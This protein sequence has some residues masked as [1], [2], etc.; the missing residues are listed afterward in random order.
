[1]TTHA[2]PLTE[3]HFEMLDELMAE[4]PHQRN[5]AEHIVE[6]IF[7]TDWLREQFKGRSQHDV[8]DYVRDNAARFVRKRSDDPMSVDLF[9]Y[10]TDSEPDWLIEGL[11]ERHTRTIFTGLVGAG[12]TELL[13]QFA[14]QVASGI[15]PFTL[16]QLEPLRVL[17]VDCENT[18]ADLGLRLRRLSDI[19]GPK[20]HREHLFIECNDSHS[21]DLTDPT[22]ADWLIEKVQSL[23]IELLIIGPLYKVGG[24]GNPVDEHTALK[25]AT[26]F[27]ELREHCS[28]IIEAH[29]TKDGKSKLPYG[30]AVWQ[31][32]PEYGL[33]LDRKGNLTPFRP[34]RRQGQWPTQLNRG[35]EWP[36]TIPTAETNPNTDESAAI[37]QFLTDRPGERFAKSRIANEMRS[38]G[39]RKR[40]SVIVAALE[41]LAA[42]GH[43]E[44]TT[45]GRVTY[46]AIR[47]EPAGGGE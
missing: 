34:A 17:I 15:H 11:I 3:I 38:Q 47:P 35:G 26:T 5:Y 8:F 28:L 40:D 41:R 18:K 23:G 10:S 14:V 36:F 6:T 46:F 24:P 1:M 13:N 32:W 2:Q 30:A 37:L 9:L 43:I 20:L 12:K 33:H 22:T 27:D 42:D 21:L 44:A 31:R 29:T 7:R 25:L 4:T 16:E 45:E 39:I 19:A